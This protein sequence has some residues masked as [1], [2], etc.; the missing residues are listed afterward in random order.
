MGKERTC[1][2][3]DEGSAQEKELEE[4]EREHM[5]RGGGS[6]GEYRLDEKADVGVA[7]RLVRFAA[8][9]TC[10]SLCSA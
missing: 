9:S 3:A 6:A 2:I 8:L 10:V 7:W 4:D 1:Y 5:E